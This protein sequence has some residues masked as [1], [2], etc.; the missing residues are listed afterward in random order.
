MLKD[1]IE[2]FENEY[3]KY[4]DKL[5]LD[6]YIPTDGKYILISKQENN[7][8][9]IEESLDIKYNKKTNK[10]EGRENLYF[11][12]I[13]N[14]DYNSKIIN[15]NKS[16]ESKKTIHSNNYLSFIIKKECLSDGKL[17]ESIIDNYYKRL[18]NP[19]L[20]YAKGRAKQI[21]E[22]V[23][24]NLD[25][26]DQELLDCIK[27][28]IKNNIFNL[29]KLGIEISGKDYLKIFV[30]APIEKYID[31]GNRYLIPNIYIKND[32]NLKINNKLYG[33][34]NNNMNLNSN[35]PFLENKTRKSKLLYILEKKEVI[36][37]QKFFDYLMNFAREGKTN[38][39]FNEDGIQA[40]K[41][42]SLIEAAFKGVYMRINKGE[43]ELEIHSYDLLTSYKYK[44][45]KVFKFKNILDVETK[46]TEINYVNPKNRKELQVIIDNVFFSKYLINN[47]FTD[48]KDIPIKDSILKRNLLLSRD[49]IFNWIYKGYENGVYGVLDKV[50]LDLIKNSI[51]FG[52]MKK[53]PH[54]FNLRQAIKNYFEGG[55]DMGD[56]IFEL[57]NNLRT[58]INSNDTSY[59][60]SD[61]EYYFSVGQFVNYLLSKSKSKNKP[62][63]L[64]N[65]FINAKNDKLIKEKLRNLYKRYNY[66]IEMHWKKIKNIYA[67]ILSYEPKGNVNQDII[68]AGY[69]HSNLIK[70]INKGEKDNE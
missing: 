65:P 45:P 51:L 12:D 29:E 7:D 2:V 43:K 23:E 19:Y 50:S 60:E 3:K 62:H 1:C 49:I 6:S 38:I 37:Q 46:N 63:S 24:A 28:W 20:K 70:E 8:F 42:D 39:Y 36:L 15:T 9:K 30:I 32:F 59:F 33:V 58:K 25:K 67:M 69:L 54:Q 52:Y 17:T 18:S 5:I 4:G 31:E 11:K 68:I 13:C 64:V 53:A 14:Y 66:N 44:L 27:I 16:I 21:Y 35:K 34:P 47:Y 10:I 55:N 22:E 48:S 26:I 56:K 41:N 40:F 57:K 61:E